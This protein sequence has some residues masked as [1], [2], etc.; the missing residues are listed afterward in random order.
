MEIRQMKEEDVPFVCAMEKEIFS[1]PWSCQDFLDMV[2]AEHAHFYV[3]D[4]ESE[5]IAYCG[6]RNMCGDGEITNVAVGE[7]FRKKGIGRKML[8][9]LLDEGGRL[10]ID[11]FTLEVRESNQVAI[12]LYT[13]LGFQIEGMRKN[14]YVSPME[15]AQI[16]WKR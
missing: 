4:V 12:A 9:Y 13:S 2:H 15:N 1:M 5:I 11:A 16:M 3:V 8:N 6:L 7:P 14:Y 10:G